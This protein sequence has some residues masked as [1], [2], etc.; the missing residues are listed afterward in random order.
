M[1]LW[2][3]EAHPSSHRGLT[4]RV[5][6]VLESK[7]SRYQQID[8]LETE[9]GE[10]LF[11]LDGMVMLTTRDEFVY[12][13][14]LAHV[15][16]FAHPAPRRVLIIGGG[17]GGTA[18]EAIKHP[19]VEHVDLVDIDE[20]VFELSRRH[21][22]E[23]ACSFDDPRVHLRAEDGAAFVRDA[24]EPYD[25][26]LVDSTEPIGPGAVL[27]GADFHRDIHRALTPDGIMACQSDTPFFDGETIRA[28]HATVRPIY[29]SLH[30]YLA[31]VPV[32]PSGLWSFTLGT[33]GG[34]AGAR[35]KALRTPPADWKLRYYSAEIHDACFALPPFAAELTR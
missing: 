13:E 29:R 8:I 2:F 34:A 12:H 22:P 23:T 21:L 17:D 11:V 10:R 14:M 18:R 30:L 28:L 3:T 6:R 20:D 33:K 19:T 4:F 16:L 25:V 15:A 35:P 5:R 9:D 7:K 24:K 27:F 1:E 31:A 26:V 32:Y